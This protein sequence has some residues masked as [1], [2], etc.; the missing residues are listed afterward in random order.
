MREQDDPFSLQILKCY[1]TLGCFCFKIR[2]RGT[3]DR[4]ADAVTFVVFAAHHV[5]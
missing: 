2:G 5:T 1:R 4:K 3:E